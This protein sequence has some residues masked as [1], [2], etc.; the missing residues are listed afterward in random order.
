MNDGLQIGVDPETP[1]NVLHML[2]AEVIRLR[3]NA[4]RVLRAWDDEP[5]T[6]RGQHSSEFYEAIGAMR[7]ALGEEVKR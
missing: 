5:N 4:A 3:T 7:N 2:H 1:Q 6:V